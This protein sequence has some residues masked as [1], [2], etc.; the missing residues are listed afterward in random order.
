MRSNARLSGR[1]PFA[2]DL[3]VTG[4]SP[5]RSRWVGW[6]IPDGTRR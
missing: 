3:L 4:S 2:R 1:A 6:P 5:G